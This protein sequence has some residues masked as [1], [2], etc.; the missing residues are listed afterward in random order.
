MN[1][2]PTYAKL[3]F[4]NNYTPTVGSI[5]FASDV[6]R[7]QAQPVLDAIVH[8]EIRDAIDSLAR[9]MQ[10][11]EDVA[12]FRKPAVEGV[13]DYS[14]NPD[15][16]REI[17]FAYDSSES[18]AILNGLIKLLVVIHPD[19]KLGERQDIGGITLERVA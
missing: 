19:Y 6:S 7:Q 16:R 18:T 13:R 9:Q 8:P 12:T 2:N 5:F 17:L 15:S 4:G 3:V 11:G 14:S 10:A 1:R